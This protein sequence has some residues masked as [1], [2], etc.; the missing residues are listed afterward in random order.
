MVAATAREEPRKRKA[1]AGGNASSAKVD[2]A[3]MTTEWLEPIF[4]SIGEE[5]M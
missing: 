2:D 4:F 1:V 5:A 3:A